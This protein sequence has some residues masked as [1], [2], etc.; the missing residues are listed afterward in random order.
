M[1]EITTED[2]AD[3]VAR[4]GSDR[5]F[6]VCRR[7]ID[8]ATLDE[9]AVQFK[10]SHERVRQILRKAGV[11]R[12]DR[13]VARSDRDEFLGVNISEADKTALRAEAARRGISMSALTADLIKDM[14]K[15]VRA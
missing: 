13:L 3:G 12:R 2:I 4:A 5:N 8:G 15:E 10:I 14:L 1:S 7:Y 11:Y 9:C 6:Q